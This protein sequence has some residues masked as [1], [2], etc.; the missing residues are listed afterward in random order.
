MFMGEAYVHGA[1]D[2]EGLVA[3]RMRRHP[4]PGPIDDGA[5]L[6]GLGEGPYDFDTETVVL[7]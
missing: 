1:M 2:G 5:W 3:A 6:D 7:V 4:N